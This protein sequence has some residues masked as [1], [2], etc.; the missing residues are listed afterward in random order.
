MVAT[1]DRAAMTLLEPTPCGTRQTLREAAAA[2]ERM[3]DIV[4]KCNASAE[5]HGPNELSKVTAAT[6]LSSCRLAAQFL[7]SYSASDGVPRWRA[8]SSRKQPEVI[9]IDV[10]D[11]VPKENSPP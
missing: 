6:L 7:R 10:L 11:S 9:A 1:H 5:P 2:F 3:V 4:E 8:C